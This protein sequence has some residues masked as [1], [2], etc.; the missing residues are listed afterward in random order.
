MTRRLRAGGRLP[1]AG[2]NPAPL[3]VRPRR[4]KAHRWHPKPSTIRSGELSDPKNGTH[5]PRRS[6]GSS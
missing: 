1:L 3:R 6:L 4:S 2:K 5:K